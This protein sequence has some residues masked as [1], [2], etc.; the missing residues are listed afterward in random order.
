MV[1]ADRAAV[2]VL[3]LV[4]LVRRSDT[5]LAEVIT[6][7]SGGHPASFGLIFSALS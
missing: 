1:S 2:W 3:F 5:V 6:T 7:A 4:L